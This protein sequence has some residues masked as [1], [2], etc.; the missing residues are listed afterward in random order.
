MR[1]PLRSDSARGLANLAIDLGD[2]GRMARARRLHRGGAVGD[3]HIESGHLSTTVFEEGD[4]S[5]R[6]EVQLSLP[7]RSH[8]VVPD[9][10]SVSATDCSCEDENDV[11]MHV[12][13]TVL[14]FAEEVEGDPALLSRWTDTAPVVPTDDATLSTAQRAFLSGSWT[15]DGGPAPL[16]PIDLGQAQRVDGPLTVDGVDA[17]PVFS[18]ALATLISHQSHQDR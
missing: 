9:A 16:Q 13:A 7:L 5:C 8:D 12:L 11:C 10:G 17:W 15:S 2:P 14:T 1:R 6:T 18:D 4:E 3:L